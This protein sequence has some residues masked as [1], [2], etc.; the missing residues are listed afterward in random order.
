VRVGE[1][2]YSSVEVGVITS[3]GEAIDGLI[4]VR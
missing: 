4:E 2:A 1:V 3:S